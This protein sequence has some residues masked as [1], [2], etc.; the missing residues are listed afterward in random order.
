MPSLKVLFA[1]DQIPDAD[2]PNS[3]IISIMTNRYLNERYPQ[4]DSKDIE[5]FQ[6]MRDAVKVLRVGGYDVS[7]ANTKRKAL[8]L[9][10]ETHFDIAIVD[11]R[12]YFDMD[13]PEEDKENTGWALCNAI[14]E[15]DRKATSTST[16]QI[17]CS[18]RFD[19]NPDIAMIAA[20]RFKLPVFKSYNEAG[21]KS[22]LASLKF[23]EKYMSSPR[24]V[25]LN[26][27]K[28]YWKSAQK[29][30][31]E[32]QTKE[33]RWSAITIVFVA[34]SVILTF[35]AVLAVLFGYAQAGTLPSISSAIT[36]VVSA[37]LLRQLKQMQQNT[38]DK[39]NNL[40]QNFQVTMQQLKETEPIR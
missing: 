34:L 13:V 16:F 7:F 11:L 18:S 26:A 40:D 5:H 6:S 35:V 3:D 9:I 33:R 2:I 39:L 32:A 25:A 10:H 23:I 4:V 37:L 12:W 17:V 30:L 28:D 14:E 1:D 21:S 15:A 31:D 19:K 38:R 36:S 8:D 22:L 24:E 29:A 27:V 20:Q